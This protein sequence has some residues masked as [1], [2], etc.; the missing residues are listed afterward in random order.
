MHRNHLGQNQNPWFCSHIS[1]P[2]TTSPADNCRP[3]DPLAHCLRV[4]CAWQ[5]SKNSNL[6]C[7]VPPY[8]KEK[9]AYHRIH[10]KD[11]GVFTWLVKHLRLIH[12][13][14]KYVNIYIYVYIVET[15][16]CKCENCSWIPVCNTSGFRKC[17][18]NLTQSPS[19]PC[20][21]F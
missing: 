11:F 14:N 16:S 17:L 4:A 15:Y 7:D 2:I 8:L 18:A 5:S 21:G 10:G 13:I 20:N 9:K 1:A 19:D 12:Y 6:S 3:L